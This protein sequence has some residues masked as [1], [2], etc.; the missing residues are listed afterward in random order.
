[1]NDFD[2]TTLTEAEER[3]FDELFSPTDRLSLTHD[4][5][6]ALHEA[7]LEQDPGLSS[8]YADGTGEL[9]DDVV[10]LDERR[11]LKFIT[12]RLLIAAAV[13]VVAG[14]GL[15]A[16]L[17]EGVTTT[18]EVVNVPLLSPELK[19]GEPTFSRLELPENV[20]RSTAIDGGIVAIADD[21][22]TDGITVYSTIDGVSWLQGE[23]LPVRNAAVDVAGDSWVVAGQDLAALEPVTNAPGESL[24]SSIAVFRSVDAGASW[25]SIP[26]DLAGD[27]RAYLTEHFTE[28]SV[29]QVNDTVLL[30]YLQESVFD[31]TALLIDNGIVGPNDRVVRVFDENNDVV[32]FS[33]GPD[34]FGELEIEPGDVAMTRNEFNES[35]DRRHS[36]AAAT[37]AV[38]SDGAAFERVSLPN[39]FFGSMPTITG[40]NGEFTSL[41]IQVTGGSYATNTALVAYSS[42]DGRSWEKIGLDELNV[43]SEALSEDWILRAGATSLEQ[44][45]DGG[46]QFDPTPSPRLSAAAIGVTPTEFGAAVIWLDLAQLLAITEEATT[47][48]ADGYTI[49]FEGNDIVVND[50]AGVEIA[51]QSMYAIPDG[52]VVVSSDGEV[53]V[54]GDEGD[55][56]FASGAAEV[57]VAEFFDGVMPDQ[58]ISWSTNGLD[59]KFASLNGIGPGLWDYYST[60]AGLVAIEVLNY[61]EAV[62]F[63]WPA[64]FAD[65]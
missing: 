44:S 34:M 48:V 20:V 45:L 26:F 36:N 49:V 11:T 55:V 56:V 63:D 50:P 31:S 13:L 8:P 52:P 41:N 33:L 1:M 47:V 65:G 61:R 57:E 17:G 39:E 46:A 40:A 42:T 9:T 53:F 24:A 58:F 60:D 16:L 51:N 7:I 5:K 27:E 54:I 18:E 3:R 15:V 22:D 62:I 30:T 10:S 21:P 64:E 37:L 6:Q 43:N 4:W 29:A 25:E 23:S 12:P 32:P 59:W 2:D 38:S 35:I 19:I 14:F 28:I